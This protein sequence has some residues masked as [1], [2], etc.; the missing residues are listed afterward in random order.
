[1]NIFVRKD[2]REELNK[3]ILTNYMHMINDTINFGK[4]SINLK[5]LTSHNQAAFIKDNYFMGNF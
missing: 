4:L 5:S 1:M 3:K 2:L